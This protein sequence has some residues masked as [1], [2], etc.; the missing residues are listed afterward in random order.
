MFDKKFND[1]I[2]YGNYTREFTNNGHDAHVTIT[3]PINGDGAKL[4][5]FE[6]AYQHVLRCAAG[7]VEWLRCPGELHV[8]GQPGH[9]Q[10]E[11]DDRLR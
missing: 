6:V 11:P 8:R 7:A 3:G 4:K 1:Y 9:H 10:H 2:Q 5:G